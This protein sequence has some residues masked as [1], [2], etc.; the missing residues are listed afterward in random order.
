VAVV[1]ITFN[2][3]ANGGGSGTTSEVTR[4]VTAG[5]YLLAVSGYDSSTGGDTTIVH[6][7]QTGTTSAW[8]E[9]AA[10]DQYDGTSLYSQE[11]AYA[12]ATNTES[13]TVRM[14]TGA[15]TGGRW[16][17]L[18]ELSGISSFDAALYARDTAATW[19]TAGLTNTNA[20]ATRVVFASWWG[21]GTGAA[22]TGGGYTDGGAGWDFGGSFARM[23]HRVESSAVSRTGGFA[24]GTGVS[25]AHITQYIFN[26]AAT[27][28]LE[29]EGFHFGLDD[30]SESAHSFVGS[31]D[32]DITTA[33][34]ETRLLRVLVNATDD[35]ASLAYTLRYQ[36]NGSGGYVAVPVGASPTITVNASVGLGTDDAQQIGTT[37][38]TTG[39]TIGASLDA[40]TEYVGLRFQSIAIPQGATITNAYL[41][42]VPSG[43]AEDEPLVTIAG[44]D[45]DNTATFSTTASD[46]T[47]RTIT[48]ATVSW[49]SA[50]LSATGSSYHNSPALTTIVQEIVDRGGWASGN[51]MGFRIQGGA[52][53]TR[54]LTIESFENTGANPPLLVIEYTGAPELYIVPSANIADGGEDTTARLGAPGGK[55]TG[56]FDT[57]RRWDNEN[58]ADSIDITADDYTEVEWALRVR[59]P[60]ATS[61]YYDFRVYA[62]AN[63]LTTYT[64]TPRWTIGAG[65]DIVAAGSISITGAA[66]LDATGTLIAAGALVIA[67]AADLSSGAVASSFPRN[68][69]SLQAIN[70]GAF[71]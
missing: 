60:A 37:M 39:T 7:T 16:I 52:T 46:I 31:Q 21:G 14:T 43:T 32:S 63:A 50:N 3:T 33:L 58:G 53:S 9:I 1:G 66:D 29:Q 41:R 40:T 8:T 45:E 2:A 59:S 68:T 62:G 15:T 24:A 51:A 12:T 11:A 35:P 57:G 42:V 44:F 27:A 25:P 28:T 30:G 5:N 34:D 22:D 17:A 69:R 64:D 36:K 38:T 55:T 49:D 26:D 4:S 56:D 65:G 19:E 23:Q 47:N 70:R 54:D 67:G 13:I 61:D 71:Y 10:A 6:S 20:A 48:T 18:I